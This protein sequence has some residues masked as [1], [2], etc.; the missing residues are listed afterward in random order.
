MRQRTL[1]VVVALVVEREA[2]FLQRREI[3]ADRARGD[4]EIAGQRVDCGPVPRRLERVQ[5]L[6]LTDDFL[7]AG[8][9]SSYFQH[10]SV[11]REGCGR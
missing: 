11:V 10:P 9:S 1:P 3:A 2:G 5:H 4:V 6:P 8:H 7:V